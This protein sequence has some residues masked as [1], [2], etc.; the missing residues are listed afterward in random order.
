MSMYIIMVPQSVYSTSQSISLAVDVY[1]LDKRYLSK[2]GGDIA[3]NL[4]INGSLDVKTNITLLEI[5]DNEDTIQGNQD[6]INDDGLTI[7]KTAGL[8]SALD[9][10]QDDIDEDTDLTFNSIT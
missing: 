8:Q 5:G 1:K 7:A 3:N 10:K 4:I 6:E 2:S 9:D